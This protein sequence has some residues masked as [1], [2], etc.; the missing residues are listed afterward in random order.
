MTSVVDKSV[1]ADWPCMACGYNLRSLS[2]S[3]QCPEC[4]YSVRVSLDAR[5]F[6]VAEPRWQRRVR[7]GVAAAALGTLGFLLFGIVST[8]FAR[9]LFKFWI[10]VDDLLRFAWPIALLPAA[11]LLR[12]DDPQKQEMWHARPLLTLL[13]AH[14]LLVILI[15]I[16]RSDSSF[17]AIRTLL[18]FYGVEPF[19]RVVE[20]WLLLQAIL[21]LS[22]RLPRR[23]MATDTV[24]FRRTICSLLLINASIDLANQIA[25]M[26]TNGPPQVGGFF[27]PDPWGMLTS[28]LM[29]I[30][31]LL[32]IPLWLYLPVH[33]IRFGAKLR[34]LTDTR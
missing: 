24:W 13:L 20:L 10:F 26:S 6:V 22:P 34:T 15:P 5:P 9:W 28:Q 32:L 11:V 25:R 2:E 1:S 3:A 31:S 17:L 30:T 27:L 12:R 8:G 23:P 29:N 19:F 4:G 16:V 18:T 33:F 7:W 14:L 21:D